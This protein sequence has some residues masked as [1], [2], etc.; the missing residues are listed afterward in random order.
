MKNSAS[1]TG[2]IPHHYDQGLGPVIFSWY[3][4][5]MAER[6]AQTKP[7]RIL[8]LAAGTGIV[9]EAID[10]HVSKDAHLTVTDLNEP[11][12]GI[13]R[14]KLRGRKGTDVSVADA[15]D[16]LFPDNTFDSIVC[17]FGIMFFPD[18]ALAMKEALRVLKPGGTYHFSVWDSWEKNVFAEMAHNTIAS[19]FDGRPPQFYKIPFG[20]HDTGEITDLVLSSGFASVDFDCVPHTSPVNSPLDFST[21]LIHGNPIGEEIVSMGGNPDAVIREVHNALRESLEHQNGL[22]LQAIFFSAIKSDS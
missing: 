4:E 19:F 18:K 22:D 12:L 14:Q 7:C 10:H 13:A 5:K 16:L 2:D 9:T 17:Q 20:Y 3:A 11:M 1:F 8:E 6:A 15:Q 21:A